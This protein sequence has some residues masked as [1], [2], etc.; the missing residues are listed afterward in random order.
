M[1]KHRLILFCLFQS[2]FFSILVSCGKDELF[3][4]YNSFNLDTLYAN[5]DTGIFENFQLIWEVSIEGYPQ[6]LIDIYLS[7]DNILSSD[8]LKLAGTADTEINTGTAQP[9]I[10][11]INFR[12]TPETGNSIRFEYSH[13]QVN[14]QSGPAIS[15][16]S[17]GEI[18]YVI[19]KFYHPL[20]LLIQT[21]RT[22]MVVQI[23]FQ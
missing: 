20:G 4:E 12:L 21:G 14:W 18:K 17:P 7:D 19:G 13:D 9:Y 15:E 23:E 5:P 1:K 11:G 2:V 6:F 8:D 16:I 22:M 3:N 10:S